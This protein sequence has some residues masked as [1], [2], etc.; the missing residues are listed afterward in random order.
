MELATSPSWASEASE[1]RALPSELPTPG[2][3]LGSLAKTAFDQSDRLAL[4]MQKLEHQGEQLAELSKQVL[5]S[6]FHLEAKHELQSTKNNMDQVQTSL[7]EDKQSTTQTSDDLLKAVKNIITEEM[8]NRDVLLLGNMRFMLE[9][10]QREVQ[11]DLQDHHNLLAGVQAEVSEVDNCVGMVKELNQA[12]GN[13]QSLCL[14]KSGEQMSAVQHLE[15]KMAT[16]F[17]SAP[18]QPRQVPNSPVPIPKVS[19]AGL[20]VEHLKLLKLSFPTY[21]RPQDDP[22]PVLYLSKCSDFLAI[23]PLSDADILA[24]FRTVLHGTARDWWEIART[25]IHTWAHFQQQFLT[26]F[27]AEDYEDELADRVRSCKQEEHE[28]IRDFAFSFRALCKRWNPT[29]TESAIVKMILRNAKPQLCSQLRGRVQTVDEL[30]RLGH[31]LE[32]DLEQI[33]DACPLTLEQSTP[34]PKRASLVREEKPLVTCWRCKGQ[35]SP[36]ACPAYKSSSADQSKKGHNRKP[37]QSGGGNVSVSCTSS[38][39]GTKKT[40]ARTSVQQGSDEQMVPQLLVVPLSIGAWAGRAVVDTGAVKRGCVEDPEQAPRG[41]KAM[42][43]RSA[44][45][46]QR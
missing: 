26:A 45:L 21:G 17:V 20:N 41:L 36:G 23:K 2:R 18:P 27:L 13:L 34:S 12:V 4:V 22:D 6:R 3:A 5:C 19:P 37:T 32:K 35:H 10:L 39:G 1:Q 33:H 25:Q 29:L 14:K 31:Q 15:H 30:V 46:R 11:Q 44:V 8:K 16:H 7:E 38:P 9:Q 42:G 43:E 40:K 28:P 24:T